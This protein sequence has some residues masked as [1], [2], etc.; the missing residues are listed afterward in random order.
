M[1]LLKNIK[2]EDQQRNREGEEKEEEEE[3]KEEE[4]KKKEKRR[5]KRRLRNHL[6]SIRR[7]RVR[8]L[9][10]PSSIDQPLVLSRCSMSI[11]NSLLELRHSEALCEDEEERKR[12]PPLKPNEK[13]LQEQFLLLGCSFKGSSSYAS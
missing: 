12:K 3:K 11:R 8:V 13:S 9:H 1:S 2:D 7:N 5:R 4:K 6:D 10:N